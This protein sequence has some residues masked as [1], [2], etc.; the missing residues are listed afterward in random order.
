M[1]RIL[2]LSALLVLVLAAVP[3]SFSQ[4][5]ADLYKSKCQMCH[6]ADG[7]GNTPIAAK[8]GVRDFHGPVVAKESDQE[9]F[10]ITKNGKDKMPA[11]AGK[12]TD[13]QIKEQVKYIRSLK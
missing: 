1:K 5:A 4:S 12:L 10:T 7:K 6:G 2:S 11:Y 8:M 13:D 9:L 3:A